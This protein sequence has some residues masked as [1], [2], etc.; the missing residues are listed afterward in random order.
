MKKAKANGRDASD[1]LDR[2]V[3]LGRMK[4]VGIGVHFRRVAEKHRYVQLD[5]DVYRDF[6][7]A[8]EVN[9]ALRIVKQLKQVG[10]RKKTA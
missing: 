1:P 2:P 3:D 5:P 7:T 4:L 6:P 9:A 10:K 8:R